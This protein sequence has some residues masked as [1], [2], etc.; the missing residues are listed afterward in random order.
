MNSCWQTLR[1]VLLHTKPDYT[2]YLQ[3][4][5]TARISWSKSSWS[6]QFVMGCVSDILCP[7]GHGHE[8]DVALTGKH[9]LFAHNL[10]ND[11]W[12][13]NRFFVQCDSTGH[14]NTA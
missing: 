2:G 1:T 9:P 10:D 14:G 4:R 7:F 6:L 8:H 12:I 5:T 11:A 3:H 13:E